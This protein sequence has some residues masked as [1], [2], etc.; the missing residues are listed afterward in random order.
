MELKENENLCFLVCR[1]KAMTSGDFR[2]QMR[3]RDMWNMGGGIILYHCRPVL[4]FCFLLVPAF[5]NYEQSLL[6]RSTADHSLSS[7]LL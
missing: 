5:Y 2:L 7:C 3:G 4:A 1:R 6:L